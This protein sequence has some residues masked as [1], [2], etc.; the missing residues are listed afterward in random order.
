MGGSRRDFLKNSGLVV[1]TAA[2]GF[3]TQQQWLSG[4]DAEMD[5]RKRFEGGGGTPSTNPS[6]PSGSSAQPQGRDKRLETPTIVTIFLRG[7]ADSLNAFVPYGDD[8]YYQVRPRINIPI[9]P[10]ADKAVLK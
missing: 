6:S 8:A 9:R 5:F 3:M 10:K 4:A 1:M 7:G 2:G